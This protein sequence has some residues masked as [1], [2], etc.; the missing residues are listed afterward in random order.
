MKRI[1]VLAAVAALVLAGCKKPE[2]PQTLEVTAPDKP[3]DELTPAGGEVAEV[4]EEKPVETV[5]T[6]PK[7]ETPKPAE[8]ERTYVVQ[9]KDTLWSIAAKF[10]GDGKLWRKIA[11][12]NG[13]TDAKKLSVGKVLKIPK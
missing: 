4:P 1:A 8:K 6:A 2:A 7:E 9:P 10:Y 3:A 13:I 12:A 11:E 5:K